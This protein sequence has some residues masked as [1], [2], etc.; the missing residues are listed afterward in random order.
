MISFSFFFSFFFLLSCAALMQ[1]YHKIVQKRKQPSTREKKKSDKCSICSWYIVQFFYF[2]FFYHLL[3]LFFASF[4]LWLLSAFSLCKYSVVCLAAFIVCMCKVFTVVC[5]SSYIEMKKKKN[6]EEETWGG[7]NF[8]IAIRHVHFNG[9]TTSNIVHI[10]S[11]YRTQFFFHSFFFYYLL[12]MLKWNIHDGHRI[13][14]KNLLIEVC[15]LF[16]FFFSP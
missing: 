3:H 7:L 5:T 13:T 6:I 11:I 4:H 2:F 14:V 16:I 15:Y 10:H 1:N 8:K 9:P 12:V